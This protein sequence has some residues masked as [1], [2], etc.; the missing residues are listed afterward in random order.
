M[1]EIDHRIAGLSPA[2]RELLRQIAAR[3]RAGQNQIQARPRP[4]RIPLTFGQRRLW[5]LDQF[6]PGMTAYNSP[7]LLWL[8]GTM[9]REAMHAAVQSLADPTKRCARCTASTTASRSS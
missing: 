2:K 3:Q 8:E 1:S 4:E 7:A 9:H 6:T 5:W